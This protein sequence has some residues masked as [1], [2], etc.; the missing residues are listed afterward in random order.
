[1]RFI[2]HFVVLCLACGVPVVA[3][4]ADHNAG[5]KVV[6][7]V[8][9]WSVVKRSF[10][11]KCD[12]CVPE[13][14]KQSYTADI[15][16]K[17]S[18]EGN[19]PVVF[20]ALMGILFEIRFADLIGGGS[21][22]IVK[23][24]EPKVLDSRYF[25]GTDEPRSPN[26]D[27]LDPGDSRRFSSFIKIF[28]KKVPVEDRFWTLWLTYEDHEAA[29][30]LLR[31]SHLQFG[32]KMVSPEKRPDALRDLA[33]RWKKFGVLPLNDSGEFFIETPAFESNSYWIKSEDLP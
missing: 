16:F 9:N 5:L 6:G 8:Y 25:T 20:P 17:V 27:V 7:T 32:F 22:A 21:E 19:E 28:V 10:V 18:N 31:R 26:F 2:L 29:R 3:Q 23:S 12:G 33:A 30:E 15:E 11:K 13:L 1:M 14:E 24:Q 4:S